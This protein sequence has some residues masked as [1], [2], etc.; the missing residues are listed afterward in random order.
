MSVHR[1]LAE[2]FRT[3]PVEGLAQFLDAENLYKSLLLWE[4][5]DKASMNKLTCIPITGELSLFHS[6]L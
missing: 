6:S 3:L 4:R 2:S 5:K 1:V